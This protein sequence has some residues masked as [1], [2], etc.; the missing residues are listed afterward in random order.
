MGRDGPDQELRR[1]A[2]LVFVDD[3]E[4][5][6]LSRGDAH[7]LGAVL[8][9]RD[10]EV[11]IAAAGTGEGRWRRCVATRLRQR[12]SSNRGAHG[13]PDLGGFELVPDGAIFVSPKPEPTIEVGMSIAKGE[14]TDWAVAK[15]VE[16]GVDRIT[17]VL[18]DRA[19]AKPPRTA[20]LERYG[21]IIRQSAMQSRRVRLPELVEPSRLET[22]VARSGAFAV[23]LAEPGG[24]LL[25]LEHPTVLVG[26]EGGWSERELA[27]APFHV[28]L[29]DAV[30]RVETAAVAAG[31]MLARLR[32]IES[33][34]G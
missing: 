18:S 14:R 4:T 29:S 32:S 26:P 27:E 2:A 11:V 25:T 13:G 33:T 21:R 15:L 20:S 9:V 3:L 22:V 28:E 12:P 6:V 30:L 10:G 5:P 1:A 23:A 8:R 16:I 17:L 34:G 19:V 24:G 7:H 31:V